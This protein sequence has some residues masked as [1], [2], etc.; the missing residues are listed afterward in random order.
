MTEN[1]TEL[2]PCPFCGGTDL[3]KQNPFTDGIICN[4]CGAIGSSSEA[5][6]NRPDILDLD[7]K[8]ALAW[9][10]KLYGFAKDKISDETNRHIK[11]IIKLL[12]ETRAMVTPSD[13]AAA[14]VYAIDQA[15]KE[16]RKAV[17]HIKCMSDYTGG[18]TSS[19]D[20]A[21]QFCILALN[22]LNNAEYEA[23]DKQ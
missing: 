12:A 7:K 4:K 14:L 11:T 6:N 15:R 20:F 18:D 17:A 9:F 13:K 2:L 22:I 21:D 5:W 19:S 16:I 10:N 3:Y 1:K 23:K 8:N